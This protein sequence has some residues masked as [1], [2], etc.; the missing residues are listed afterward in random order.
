M[1]T[2]SAGFEQSGTRKVKEQN[3]QSFICPIGK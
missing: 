2:A 3:Y 1:G